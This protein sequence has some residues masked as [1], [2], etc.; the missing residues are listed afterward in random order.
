MCA[1]APSCPGGQRAGLLAAVRSGIRFWHDVN[2][3]N[4]ENW[5]QP[6]VSVPLGIGRACL[7]AQAAAGGGDL[8]GDFFLARCS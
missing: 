3:T 1:A 7:C 5:Y 6:Q 4:P 2:V 8:A